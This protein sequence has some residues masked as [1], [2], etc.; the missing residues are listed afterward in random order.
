MEKDL[1]G[2][3]EELNSR[4]AS[5]EEQKKV[6]EK[7]NEIAD[8]R[9]SMFKALKDMYTQTQESVSQTRVDLVDQLTVLGVVNA[10]LDNARAD[11]KEL[12]GARTGKIRMAEINT[13][14]GKRYRAHGDLMKLLVMVCLPVMILVVLQKKGMIPSRLAN[15]LLALGIAIAIFLVGHRILDLWWRNNMNYDEYDW[16]WDADANDP[17]VIQYDVQAIKS[18]ELGR[19][20]VRG[21]EEAAE[22]VGKEFEFCVGGRCC[23]K[24]THYDH[25]KGTCVVDSAKDASVADTSLAIQPGREGFDTK[26]L[27]QT[28]YM[29]DSGAAC[30]WRKKPTTV[31]AFDSTGLVA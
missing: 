7:V 23:G 19:S 31:R 22:A 24:G 17:T 13:Y 4:D 26:Y 6:M 20:L 29:E 18:S 8:M 27:T 9:V 15:P 11:L 16:A 28:S 10:E 2:Q 30:T 21:V 25:K 14:Y 5:Y 1:Y 3:L 12:E